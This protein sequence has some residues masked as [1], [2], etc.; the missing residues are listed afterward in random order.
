MQQQ[1]RDALRLSKPLKAPNGRST[2]RVFG[3]FSTLLLHL[4]SPLRALIS[5]SLC[6]K[7]V[8]VTAVLLV[9]GGVLFSAFNSPQQV[10]AA[11]STYLNFQARLLTNTGNLVPDGTYYIEFKLYDT[12]GSGASAQGVCSLNS[13]SDDCWWMETRSNVTVVNGYFSVNLGS[14]TAFGSSIDW[15]S[16]LWLTMNIGGTSGP[17]WNGEMTPRILLTAVPLALVANNVN[18]GNTSAA[19]TNS[20]AT[21]IQSGNATGATSNSGNVTVDAGTATGTAGQVLIANNYA[22]LLQMGRVGAVTTVIGSTINLQSATIATNATTLALFDTT[23]TTVTAFSAVTGTLNVAD[24]A[25]TKTIDIG[26]VTNSGTD[27]INIATNATAADII[28]IGSSHASSTNLLTGGNSSLNLVNGTATLTG[29]AINLTGAITASSTLAVQGASVTIGASALQ[30]LLILNDGN[31]GETATI[32]SGNIAANTVISIP[33]AVG[34]TDTFCLVT[35]ANCSSAGGIVQ[36]PT[37]TAQNTIQP[38]TT[39]VV[40]LTING[41]NTG[42]AANALNVLQGGA[43]VLAASFDSTNATANGVLI[44]VQS[45]SSSQYALSV[46]AN[47]GATSGLYVRADGNVGIGTASPASKLDVVVGSLATNGDIGIRSTATLTMTSGYGYGQQNTITVTPAS[48]PGTYTQ[49]VGSNLIVTATGA[50]AAGNANL[51]GAMTSTLAGTSSAIGDAWTIIGDS[52]SNSTGAVAG[53]ARGVMGRISASGSGNV[54]LAAGYYGPS[55]VTGSTGVISTLYGI[56]LE[57]QDTGANVTTGYGIYQAGTDANRFVGATTYIPTAN[58]AVALTVNGTSGTAATALAVVQTGTATAMTVSQSTTSDGLVVTASSASLTG[59]AFAVTSNSTGVVTNGLARFNFTGAH[60]GNGL[61]VDDVTTAGTVAALNANAL[62]GGNGQVINVNALTTGKALTITRT[63]TGLTTAGANTGSLLNI[64]S[65][66]ETAFTGSL[67]TINFAGTV[68]GN[69]GTL[70][71]LNSSGAAQITKSLVVTNSSTGTT[72]NGMVNFVFNGARSTAAAGFQIDD[73]ST[74]LA[75]AMILNGNSLTSGFG[76]VIN[77]NALTSGSGLTVNSS[78]LGLTG[79]LVSITSSGSN[80]GVTGNALKVGLTGAL[81]V[82][83]ALNVTNGG[84]ASS[85]SFR[86][87]DDGTYTDAT[88]FLIDATGNT[89]IGGTTTTSLFNVGSTAQFQVSSAGAIAAITGYTQ[90]SGTFNIANTSTTLLR[91]Q[92]TSAADTMFTANTGT[93]SSGTAGNQLVVGNSTGTDTAL[94]LFVLDTATADPTTNGGA[95]VN[96]SMFYNSTTGSFRCYIASAWRDCSTPGVTSQRITLVPEYAGGVL[97]PDGTNNSGTMI[98]DYASLHNY[99]E[100]STTQS[101]AQD[102]D[103]VVRTQLPSNFVSTIG[104]NW[105]IWVYATDTTKSAVTMTVSDAA[106]TTCAS[107]TVSATSNTTWQQKAMAAF[108]TCTL[109]ANDVVT[110]RL[111]MSAQTASSNKTRVGEIQFDY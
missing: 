4:F 39:A 55:P 27:T 41:T 52:G 103:I 65:G 10:A 9:S 51:F 38:A 85:I 25:T 80:A 17:S 98:S 30:G 88:P 68:V 104:T 11:P 81:S 49:Y 50:N 6:R 18:S 44:D 64:Q 16:Q 100:W 58:S 101:S 110:I 37:S 96:G 35:Y 1:G 106:G 76:E 89:T 108:T 48:A 75:T 71:N 72:S 77:V 105:K 3:V 91:L 67:A 111:N 61:Q 66:I 2:D 62:L 54:N 74:T 14:T 79:D 20:A 32:Q 59:N 47:N 40:G 94:T 24:A 34:T 57:Q 109:A 69:T 56:Y 22:S 19:S 23:A 53:W 84:A 97:S 21:T 28:S 13:S 95:I 7:A 12:V 63:G 73:S 92:N 83:T 29:T 26:G 5:T 33:A 36:A 78:S 45:S 93:R 87:N 8:L 31:G 90:T 107:T 82:G 86:I 15:S 70:L 60:T 46:T 43:A 99:Y 42:T 102:Y